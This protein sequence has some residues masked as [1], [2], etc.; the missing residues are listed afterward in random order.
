MESTL[1]C[2][3]APVPLPAMLMTPLLGI[4]YQEPTWV[5]QLPKALPVQLLQGLTV[6]CEL[7]DQTASF[8][9]ISSKTCCLCVSGFQMA[10]DPG[11]T[12]A[13]KHSS[14]H[15]FLAVSWF[16]LNSSCLCSAPGVAQRV[17]PGCDHSLE[18]TC[19]HHVCRKHLHLLAGIYPAT[20]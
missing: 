9:A 10:Q 12:Q 20:A 15:H 17:V 3:Q 1:Q 5:L 16:P 18:H 6:P 11:R 19:S 7:S 8:A 4:C 2:W 13:Q 14:A